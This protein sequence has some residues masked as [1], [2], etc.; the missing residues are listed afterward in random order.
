MNDAAERRGL[1]DGSTCLDLHPNQGSWCLHE[2]VDTKVT[3]TTNTMRFG[4]DPRKAI[5]YL[6]LVDSRGD[7]CHQGVISGS[8]INGT[9]NL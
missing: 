8:R 2:Y 4:I 1:Q 9:Q 3:S 6:S 5:G 7:L